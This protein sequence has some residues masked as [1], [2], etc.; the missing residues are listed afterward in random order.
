VLKTEY[1]IGSDQVIGH[2]DIKATACPGKYFPMA[3]ISHSTPQ[4]LWGAAPSA[5]E[6]VK[7]AR[8]EG[9]RN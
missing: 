7:L 9:N 4:I 6:A 5:S 2:S 1:G 3:E 8:Q